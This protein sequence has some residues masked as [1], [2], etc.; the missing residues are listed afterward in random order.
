MILDGIKLS[1]TIPCSKL[2]TSTDW[3]SQI[4][5]TELKAFQASSVES[6]RYF[7]I[8][9]PVQVGG[10]MGI[11]ISVHRDGTDSKS[12]E[13]EHFRSNLTHRA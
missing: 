2:V 8:V 7:K 12:S 6:S 4:I 1:N 9:F 11:H 13:P 5:R 3:L 10:F